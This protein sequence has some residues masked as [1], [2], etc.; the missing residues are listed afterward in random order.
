M[1]RLKRLDIAVTALA[2]GVLLWA[3]TGEPAAAHDPDRRTS[4]MSR[5]IAAEPGNANLYAA[6][7][8][9]HRALGRTQ[10]ALADL[11]R[12]ERLAPA[13]SVVTL[14][15]GS[16]LLDAARHA[17]ALA[18]IEP[19]VRDH[20]DH[21]GALLIRARALSAMRRHD[22]AVVAYTD[23]IA[24]LTTPRPQ[25][26]LERAE[27]SMAAGEYEDAL[28]GLDEGL[29]RVGVVVSLQL[30][31]ID[32]ELAFARYDEALGRLQTL[33]DASQRQERWQVR[34]GSILRLAGRLGKAR[35]S[36]INAL[37]TIDALPSRHRLTRSVQALRMEAQ[38]SLQ[39]L[40]DQRTEER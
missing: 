8:D 33:A 7:A 6:R 14:V 35:E 30:Y 27:A 26:Y 3:M 31:A 40:D 18:C 15:R 4:S 9:L 21:G 36:Y 38:T 11:D 10:E 34:R 25:H 12:A 5:K 23:A 20:P 22:E 13:L 1:K 24:A 39:E 19:Y 2:T 17:E 32:L 29:L 37:A 16:T 28:C